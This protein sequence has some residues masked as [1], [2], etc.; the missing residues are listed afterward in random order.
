VDVI[1]SDACISSDEE[2]DEE[3][4]ADVEFTDSSWATAKELGW[5]DPNFKEVSE[6][7][8][9]A[10]QEK[11]D[12]RRLTKG[13]AKLS[14]AAKLQ[15]QGCAIVAEV[16]S[17]NP[18]LA[19]L[20]QVLQPYASIQT[21]PPT[22]PP[23]KSGLPQV[24]QVGKVSAP[25]K[26]PEGQY[27]CR[28]CDKVFASHEGGEAHTRETHT[29]LLGPCP[30]CMIFKSKAPGSYRTHVKRCALKIKKEPGTGDP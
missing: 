4:G 19:P 21:P 6:A 18:S 24:F 7:V 13:M 1:D 17:R 14:K 8:S 26:T 15:A 3:V 25:V 2:E 23:T 22:L 12:V 11:V 28:Y 27:K 20:A 10:A 29:T 16:I 30:H 9:I 5:L